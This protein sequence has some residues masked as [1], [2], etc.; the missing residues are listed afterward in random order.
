[1]K[2]RGGD[3]KGELYRWLDPYGE[4]VR[5]SGILQQQVP[6]ECATNKRLDDFHLA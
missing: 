2:E 3:H 5:P 6:P 1:M 4:E